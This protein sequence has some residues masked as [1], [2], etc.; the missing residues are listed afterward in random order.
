VRIEIQPGIRLF[1]DVDGPSL[2]PDGPALVERPTVV[3]L[4]GGPGADHAIFKGSALAGLTDVAQVVFYDHRSQGRSDVRPS[5]EWTLDTWADDVVRLCDALGISKPIVIGA[6]F[7]GMVAQRYLARHP[8]HPSK[9]VLLCTSPRMDLDTVSGSFARIGGEAAGDAA[10]RM[11]GGDPDALGDFMTHCLPLYATGETDPFAMMRSAM[12]LELQNH[13]FAG[14][15]QTMDLTAGL[16]I[17]ACPVLIVGGEL[18]PV[19]PIEMSE[20]IASSLPSHLVTFERI[21]GASHIDVGDRA[22]IEA[23]RRFIAPE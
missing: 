17:A 10:R 21:A 18:D 3:L 14:E 11:F 23:V 15:A 20:L 19:C 5:K 4:H 16:A 9:V 6:S 7:G 1:V 12:N 8:E 2:V 13:F 22:G